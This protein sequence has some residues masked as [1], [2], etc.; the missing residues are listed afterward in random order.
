MR[1]R[2]LAGTLLVTRRAN[3][4][5][6]MVREIDAAVIT[7]TVARLAIEATHFLPED[8]ESYLGKLK[9]KIS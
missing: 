5:M 7:E 6:P 3:E 8:V 9:R 4:E 2:F 1:D